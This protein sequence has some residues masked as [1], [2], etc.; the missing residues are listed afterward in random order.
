MYTGHDTTN[1]SSLGIG[2]FIQKH[3]EFIFLEGQAF[4]AAGSGMSFPSAPHEQQSFQHQTAV[5]GHKLSELGPQVSALDPHNNMYGFRISSEAEL[6]GFQINFVAEA[7]TGVFHAFVYKANSSN[8]SANEL[9]FSGPIV[10]NI[11][12][13]GPLVNTHSSGNTLWEP[14]NRV[15]IKPDSYLFIASDLSCRDGAPNETI[16]N[17]N[18]PSG[19]RAPVGT[20]HATAYIRYI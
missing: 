20:I 14:D 15:V 13:L 16:W 12:N 2:P 18:V 3:F 1:N 8:P 9:R 11:N 19:F 5:N 4:G 10:S 6:L 17:S 7:N